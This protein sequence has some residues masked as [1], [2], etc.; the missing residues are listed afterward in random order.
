MRMVR[1]LLCHGEA[2]IHQADG[3]LTVR[4]REFSKPRY[5]SLELSCHFDVCMI[6]IELAN[7]L[8]IYFNLSHTESQSIAMK[9][10]M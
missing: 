6:D 1:A 4:T 8:T 3:R 5:S 9:I 10:S 7:K 2:S